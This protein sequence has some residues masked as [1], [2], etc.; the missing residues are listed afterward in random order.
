MRTPLRVAALALAALAPPAPAADGELKGAKRPGPVRADLYNDAASAPSAPRRGADLTY[1]EQVSFRSL[2]PDQDN[3]AT[4]SELVRGYIL[5]SLIGS[6]QETWAE[7]DGLAER[8]EVEDTILL[9]DGSVLRGKVE[10]TP[11][12]YALGGTTHRKETVSEVRLGTAFTFH[13]RKDVVFHDGQ[14]FTARDV[15]FTW[16]LLRD[17]RNGMPSIQN[18]INDITE[19]TVLDDYTVRLVYN[20]QYWM[21][22][23]VV[24]GYMN[25]RPHKAWDPDGLIDS[26]PD[27]F[28]KK[29]N[30]HPLLLKPVGT[31]PYQLESLK[32]D[33]EVVLKRFDRYWDPVRTPQR[34][35]IH[36]ARGWR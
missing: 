3:S 20:R 26:D 13:L 28:F 11:D 35:T 36:T 10:E 12:G 9:R 5:E 29:L 31:G 21:A 2:D 17:P 25:I 23:S 7:R 4:T 18:Y 22:Q 16:K 15:A 8:W 1:A 19:C 27:A 32:K 6:D 34:C 14:P 24:G 30:E 33:F